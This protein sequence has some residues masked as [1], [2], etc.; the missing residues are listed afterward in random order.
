LNKGQLYKSVTPMKPHQGIMPGSKNYP[1]L[2]NENQ[3]GRSVAE[4]L[5]FISS[6]GPSASL[7]ITG[8]TINKSAR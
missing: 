2:I 3:S 4:L 1:K 8:W 7:R 6:V 5:S